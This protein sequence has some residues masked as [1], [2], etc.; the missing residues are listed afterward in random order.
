M[1]YVVEELK[2]LIRLS[3]RAFSI[4]TNKSEIKHIYEI[5]FRCRSAFKLLEIDQKARILRPGFKVLDCGG[6]PGS[7]TQVAV[8]KTNSSGAKEDKPKGIVI[9]IDLLPIYPIEGAHTISSTNFTTVKAQDKIREILGDEKL[10]CVLS[11]M[12][13]N[14][15]GVRSLD[16]ENITDLCYSV[17]RFAIQMSAENSSLLMKV[18]DNGAVPQLERDINR[19]YR[20]VKTVKP[21]ASRSDSAEKFVL[22][23]GFVGIK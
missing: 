3:V 14:A 5:T 21:N 20:I 8:I 22:A 15:T 10:D 23:K 7:W 16:Q 4:H 1:K 9:G 18:W 19:Y 17:L 12:A 6:A 2:I 13:P 11:D